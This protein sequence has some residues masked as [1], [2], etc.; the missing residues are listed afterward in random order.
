MTPEIELLE[1]Y[2]I[3]FILIFT[4]LLSKESFSQKYP[5]PYVDSL[6]TSG[7]NSIINQDYTKAKNTFQELEE[8]RPQLPLGKI[9]LAAVDITKAF[10]YSEKFDSN[11]IY[12]NLLAAKDQSEQLLE[13]NNRNVWDQYF[14]ALSEGFYSYFQALNKNWLSALSNGLSSVSDFEKCLDI[15]NNF[16]EAYTAIGTYKYWKSKKTEF[17]NWLPFMPNDEQT[18]INYL[19]ISIKHFY[20][21]RI[22]YAH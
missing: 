11:L 8:K 15:D 14:L 20:M 12:K 19:K 9:Y 2:K 13:K 1:H 18:G 6:I 10:D 4:F 22:T 17:L 5:D 3:L 7:I 16:Y 21:F